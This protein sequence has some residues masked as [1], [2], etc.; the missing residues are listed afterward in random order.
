MKKEEMEKRISDI[1][2]AIEQ[3]AANHNALLG[4]LNEARYFLDEMLKK[5]SEDQKLSEGQ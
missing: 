3:S 1:S 5:E 4:R 2:M